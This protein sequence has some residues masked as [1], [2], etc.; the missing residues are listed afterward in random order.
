MMKLIISCMFD[1]E[2]IFTDADEAELEIEDNIVKITSHNRI[3][4]VPLDKINFMEIN[5]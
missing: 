2:F 3:V 5:E 1:K 4:V